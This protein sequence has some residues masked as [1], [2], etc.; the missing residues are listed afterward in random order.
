LGYDTVREDR[1]SGRVV[2]ELSARHSERLSERRPG[3]WLE[4][5]LEGENPLD[6]LIFQIKKLF[7]N[8]T[9]L[10]QPGSEAFWQSAQIDL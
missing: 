7:K 6:T 5:G 8:E 1:F 2:E 9:H 4:K 10:V 3:A